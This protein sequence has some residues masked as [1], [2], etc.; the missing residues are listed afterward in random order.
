MVIKYKIMKILKYIMVF[1]VLFTSCQNQKV[2]FP[3]YKYTAV[4][5]PIQYPLRTLI[6]GDSRSDNT[7]DKKLQFHI[8]VSIGGIY[9]NKKSW[10][11]NYKVDYSLVPPD[12]VNDDGDPIKVLPDKYYTLSPTDKIM[13]PAGS[14]NGLILVQLTD[15][16]LDDPLAVTGDYVIPLRI[17]GSN[18][19]SILTGNPYVSNPNKNIPAD[20]DPGAQPKDFVLFGI[21]Y[22][23][24]YHGNYLHRGK[25]VTLDAHGDTVSSVIYHQK[26]VVDDQLWAVTTTG[27]TTVETN[28]VGAK[29]D[30]DTHLAL[31]IDDN[32]TIKVGPSPASLYPASG[33]GRYLKDA[34][35]WGGVKHNAMYLNYIYKDGAFNHVVTDTLVFRDNGVVYEEN[36]IR[37]E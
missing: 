24:S 21:K 32:G 19:D 35:S 22:I 23:N 27:K 11:V 7:L 17:T 14:F 33:V 12:L 16:F 26:Y 1:C 28:G 13:I 2:A 25:D 20:W 8:G 9:E 29:F 15:A 30:K 31:D 5:F 10:D 4:Y 6:L 3:D 34:E 36:K 18:A 37:L